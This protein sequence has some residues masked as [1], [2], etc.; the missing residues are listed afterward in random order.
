ME[1]IVPLQT[2]EKVFFRQYVEIL[3]PVIKLRP[4]ELDVLAELLFHNNRLKDIEE[5]NRWKLIFDYDNKKEMAEDLKISVASLGNNLSYLRKRGI[6][7][8]NK[9]IQNLLVYPGKNF[10][11]TFKFSVGDRKG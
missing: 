11:L 7:V 9:V 6:I 8:D 5:K 10:K 1:K 4:K 3:D 2:S